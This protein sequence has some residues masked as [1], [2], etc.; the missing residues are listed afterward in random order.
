MS[1]TIKVSFEV[2]VAKKEDVIDA[3]GYFKIGLM[4]ILRSKI[5]GNFDKKLYYLTNE[6]D[7][8]E[9]KGRL[10]KEMVYVTK[11]TLEYETEITIQN[12]G[13]N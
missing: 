2:R 9:F 4:Y 12:H 1:E 8:V 11:H 10:L 5:T 7:K 3:L 6:T 13:E